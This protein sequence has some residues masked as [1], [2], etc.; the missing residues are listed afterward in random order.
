MP[1]QAQKAV[2]D[3]GF[4][5]PDT[6]IK[7]EAP[8]LYYYTIDTRG[9]RGGIGWWYFYSEDDDYTKR[10]AKVGKFDVTDVPRALVDRDVK[11]EI[12]GGGSPSPQGHRP[13]HGLLGLDVFCGIVELERAGG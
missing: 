6:L 10:R 4:D 2:H 8:N 12:V 9:M 13:P 5:A 7:C 11:P 1:P 3:P